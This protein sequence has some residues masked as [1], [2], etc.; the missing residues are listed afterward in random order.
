MRSHFPERTSAVKRAFSLL[1]LVILLCLQALAAAPVLHRH[2][3]H[4]ASQ[5]DH[6]CAVTMLAQ[7]KVHLA[8]A[9]PVVLPPAAFVTE[10]LVPPVLLLA[11]VEYGLLPG[12]APPCLS[13]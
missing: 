7:G 10:T 12:R 4:D 11:T 5:A 6:A 13:A 9:A 8:S 3:H 2:L 1:C